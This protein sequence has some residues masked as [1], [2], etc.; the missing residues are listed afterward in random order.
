MTKI[1]WTEKTWN[2]LAGCTPVSAGC[3]HCYA[4]PQA[5]RLAAMGHAKYQG[6][7]RATDGR[8]VWTGRINL[9]EEALM[10][11]LRVRRPTMWFV[12]SMSDLFHPDVP[13]DFVDRVFSVMACCPRHTFQVLTKRPERLVEFLTRESVSAGYPDQVRAAWYDAVPGDGAERKRLKN[14]MCRDYPLPNVWLG[15]SAEN[16]ETA[17]E[18]LER[19]AGIDAAVK[20]ASLEPLLGPVDLD[21]AWCEWWQS[22]GLGWV[23]V[24]G[25]SGPRA[26]PCDVDW[27]R[28]IVRRCR[29]CAVPCFV[30]QVGARPTRRRFDSDGT[31]R[32]AW[33]RFCVVER[34]PDGT[35]T[36]IE[37][38][39]QLDELWT[40]RPRDPK[41]G[42]PAEWPED[43]RVREF[44]ERLEAVAP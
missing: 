42:R 41:G 18:R 15:T 30:K 17:N 36:E 4:I 31:D 16:Q 37:N 32:A 44:P 40:I 34:W 33:Y 2:P 22:N 28:A 14:S 26:R 43:L 24:G 19:L 29:A 21:E 6:V 35:V 20:F 39:N 8:V 12:N 3:A 5:R 13:F 7:T 23:I 38:P 11:P 27:I 25:E 9:D 1:E 10:L